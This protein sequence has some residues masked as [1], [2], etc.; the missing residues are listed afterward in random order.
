V[1]QPRDEAEL[2]EIV[3]WAYQQGSLSPQQGLF[4]LRRRSGQKGLVI[5]PDERRWLWT[6]PA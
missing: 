2:V 4:G 1:V 3:R 6:R 5:S